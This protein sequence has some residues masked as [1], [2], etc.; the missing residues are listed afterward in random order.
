MCSSILLHFPCFN[1][2]FLN[3]AIQ[4]RC[5]SL[6]Q[7]ALQ[8]HLEARLP[9][10]GCGALFFSRR[11]Q[12]TGL[13]GL[14]V[15]TFDVR[16]SVRH[17]NGKVHPSHSCQMTSDH[18]LSEQTKVQTRRRLGLQNLPREEGFTPFLVRVGSQVTCAQG[19]SCPHMSSRRPGVS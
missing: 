7:A 10:L 18:R 6:L 11:H 17:S 16:E 2:G 9:W 1:L 14:W 3:A 4:S 12:E 5:T 13:F 19:G 8:G 15:V